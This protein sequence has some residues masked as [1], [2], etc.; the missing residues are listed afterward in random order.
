[1][2]KDPFFIFFDS[3]SGSTFL[4]DLLVKHGSVAIPPESNFIPFILKSHLG[5]Q[6]TNQNLDCWIELI[7]SDAKFFDWGLKKSEIVCALKD[8]LPLSTKEFI[9]S[10]CN[11]YKQ[12]FYPESK[13]F[14][15]K[16]NYNKYYREINTMF[17]ASCFITIIRDGRAVF[18]SKKNSIYSVTGLPFETSPVKSARAWVQEMLKTSNILNE[19]PNLSFKLRYEDLVKQPKEL[20]KKVL[21]FIGLKYVDEPLDNYGYHI[22][23]RYGKELH[24]N[25]GEMPLKSRRSAWTESLSQEEIYMFENIAADFLTEEGYK[26]IAPPH[27]VAMKLKFYYRSILN[28]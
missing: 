1:M 20:T 9:L 27:T 11:L 7:Y 21:D 3:R 10:I 14:G 26:L 17:P 24:K 25:V 16:K 2:I 18:N 5:N 8:E 6:V 4:A 15:I 28:I 12:K 23:K 13:H 22:P 19:L